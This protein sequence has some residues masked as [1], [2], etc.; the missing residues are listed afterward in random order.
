[1]S[2]ILLTERVEQLWQE[3]FAHADA[4]I[5]DRKA[6]RGLTA[7][8]GS[9]FEHEDNTASGRGKL[10]RVPQNIQDHLA[11]LDLIPDKPIFYMTFDPAVILYAFF[12]ALTA[13]EG[14]DLLKNSGKGELLI[15]Q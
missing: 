12:F 1:L 4:G 7:K 3:F 6:E 13:N 15:F 9:F 2:G 14:I 5:A 8:S 10:N 11:Q